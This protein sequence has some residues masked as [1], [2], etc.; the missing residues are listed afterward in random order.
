MNEKPSESAAPQNGPQGEAAAP[1]VR[2]KGSLLKRLT[3]VALLIAAIAAIYLS[4]ASDY[5]SYE[6]LRNNLGMLQAFVTEHVAA[7]VAALVLVYAV[8]TAL[9]IPAMSVATVAAGVVYGLWLGTLG[10]VMGATLG[11]AAIFLLVK[12]SLGDPLRKKVR[13][14][15]GKFERGFQEDAFNYLLALR[16][17]PIFPFWVLNI[18]PALL[19]VRLRTYVL[20]TFLGIIPGTFVYVWVGKGA[21]ETIAM[22]GRVA[23]AELLFE[24][25]IIG[26]IIGLA[27][28]SL[29]PVIMRKVR[30]RTPADQAGETAREDLPDS[31]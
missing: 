13:P 3:L 7:A 31:Q 27:A 14:W 6:A 12:T 2:S 29:L 17:V 16:L 8:G 25:H 11:S 15:L 23:P 26:P 30:G 4:G 28:L 22:G 21:A 9:S 10:V 1:P 20:S 24:P 18:A 5:I 19:G